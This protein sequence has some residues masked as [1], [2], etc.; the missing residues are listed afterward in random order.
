MFTKFNVISFV[1]NKTII[2]KKNVQNGSTMVN[3]GYILIIIAANRTP[4]L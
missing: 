2:A 1:V 3:L 4:I